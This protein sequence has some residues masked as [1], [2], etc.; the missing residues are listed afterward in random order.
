MTKIT[1]PAT[2]NQQP[3]TSNQIPRP[4]K[5]LIFATQNKHKIEEINAVL[6][7]NMVEQQ[8]PIWNIIGLAEINCI[9]DIPETSDTLEGNALQK[10]LYISEGFGHDCFADDTGLEVDALD[11]RPGVYSARYAG[12]Q[13]SFDDNINKVLDELKDVK[14]RTARFRTVIALVLDSD[15]YFFEGKIEGHIIHERRGSSGFGYDPVFVPQGY[16][17]TFAEMTLEE[18]NIISHRALA[19]KK[20][21]DF[22]KTYDLGR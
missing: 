8:N 10:A 9:D 22:L 7:T 15:H 14:N 3:A 13:R 6:Q 17:K 2:S 21:I 16:D 5:N 12:S 19:V 20:L 18:K 4:M 1:Q 11:G